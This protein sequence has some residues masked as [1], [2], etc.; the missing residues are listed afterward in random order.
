MDCQQ[1]KLMLGSL[2]DGRVLDSERFEITRHLRA[3]PDC[4]RHSEELRAVR[5]MV[6]AL[7]AK[8][9]P[10]S[11]ALSLRVAASKEAQRRRL[12]AG[13]RGWFRQRAESFQLSVQ[14]M[15]RP[16]ALPA[17]GGLFSTFILF[18]AVLTNYQGIVR[19]PTDDVP[20]ILA[21]GATM[22][23]GLFS[24][25][26]LTPEILTVDVLVDGQGRAI[27]FVLPPEMGPN[28]KELNRRLAQ[29]LLF[30]QFEPATAFGQPTRTWVKISYRRID[31][32]G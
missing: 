22:K 9:V 30:T 21:T 1:T 28:N 10:P 2:Q 17:A 4:A 32:K 19:E 15:M 16:L 29:A 3:C 5:S 12:Y 8:P 25:D 27:D 6:N 31:V 24:A 11:L 18:S 14:N 26:D 7:P 20:T 23:S 13:I